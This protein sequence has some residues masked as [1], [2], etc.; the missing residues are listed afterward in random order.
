MIPYGGVK[1]QEK[2]SNYLK[3]FENFAFLS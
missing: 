2:N 3:I 1:M